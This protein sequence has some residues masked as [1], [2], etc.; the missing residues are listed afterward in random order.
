MGEKRDLDP[1]TLVEKLPM[2]D[3]YI[4][5]KMPLDIEGCHSF[6]LKL[7]IIRESLANRNITVDW[8]GGKNQ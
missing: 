8:R 7:A 3:F 2:R 1:I 6:S 5:L 4:L